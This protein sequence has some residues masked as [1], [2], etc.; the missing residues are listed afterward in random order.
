MW[1]EATL[2]DSPALNNQACN[3][4]MS[5]CDVSWGDSISGMEH[6]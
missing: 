2:L 5:A 3:V 4:K 1:L 6:H